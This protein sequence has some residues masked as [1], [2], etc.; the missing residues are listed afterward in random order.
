M[1]ISKR[2]FN[3]QRENIKLLNMSAQRMIRTMVLQDK[4]MINL[5]G[6]IRFLTNK[7]DREFIIATTQDGTK[8]SIGDFLDAEDLYPV[9][10]EE[11]QTA[12]L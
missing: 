9:V 7:K 4:K 3:A 8:L 10:E 6:I 1:F 2:K 12:T 5:V 11:F